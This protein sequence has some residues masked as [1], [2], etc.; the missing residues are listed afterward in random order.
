MDSK[1]SNFHWPGLSSDL[2]LNTWPLHISNSYTSLLSSPTFSTKTTTWKTSYSAYHSTFHEPG[3]SVIKPSTASLMNLQTLYLFPTNSLTWQ[4]ILYIGLAILELTTWNAIQI[5]QQDVQ[6]SSLKSKTETLVNITHLHEQQLH[7]FDTSCSRSSPPSHTLVIKFWDAIEKKIQLATRT[8]MHVIHSAH[9]CLS[10]G[11]LLHNVLYQILN[12]TLDVSFCNNL[13]SFIMNPSDLLQ[14]EASNLQNS[15]GDLY[16]LILHILHSAKS[17]IPTISTSN[18]TYLWSWT[19]APTT[20]S[21]LGYHHTFKL[22]PEQT[23]IPSS[24]SGILSFV[25]KGRWETNITFSWL[26]ALYLRM[27]RPFR[28]TASS[29]SG[30]L[31][32]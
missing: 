4:R 30:H 6:S 20:W 24:V 16:I 11:T 9:H 3:Q 31:T 2:L 10:A 12:C 5:T 19:S 14:I 1:N 18:L 26:K 13:V 15:K 29:G 28:T 27:P 7:H 22:C 21:I 25:R 23:S 17:W 8:Y 32:I